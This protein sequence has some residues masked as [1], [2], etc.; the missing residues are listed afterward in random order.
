MSPLTVLVA[1]GIVVYVIGQQVVGSSVSGKRLVVLPVVVTLIGILD[2][3]ANKPHPDATDIVLL[4][5]SAVVAI[6][7]EAPLADLSADERREL[8]SAVALLGGAMYQI[9]TPPPPLAQF[10][11]AEPRLGHALL[12]L[13]GRLTRATRVLI[14][15]L[16]AH[17]PD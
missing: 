2:I 7:L 9:A 16:E 4:T 8:V 14:A 12:D 6:A 10:Y 1:I 13:P 5:V 17:V 11:E 15:G 3:S